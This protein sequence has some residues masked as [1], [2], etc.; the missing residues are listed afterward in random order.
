MAGRL[1]IV[2]ELPRGEL[3]RALERMLTAVWDNFEAIVSARILG[4]DE[5]TI[6]PA[7][8]SNTITHKLGKAPTR[9]SVVRSKNVTGAV[10]ETAASAT[11]LTLY[12][13]S[14]TGTPELV[15]RAW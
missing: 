15:V 6:T 10:Y 4:F 14:V 12:V 7:A 11:T 5:V 9:W 2:R 13:V 3:S 8:G 1:S